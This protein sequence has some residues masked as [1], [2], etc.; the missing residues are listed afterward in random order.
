[1]SH[2][3]KMQNMK[4]QRMSSSSDCS[5]SDDGKQPSS[6]MKYWEEIRPS[7]TDEEVEPLVSRARNQHLEVS[8]S[9]ECQQNENDDTKIENSQPE[10]SPSTVQS[11]SVPHTVNPNEYHALLVED[12]NCENRQNIGNIN[13]LWRPISVPDSSCRSAMYQQWRSEQPRYD[14]DTDLLAEIDYQFSPPSRSSERVN[15]IDFLDWICSGK[16]CEFIPFV[17]IATAILAIIWLC[18]DLIVPY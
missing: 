17:L 9:K 5:D 13:S 15:S 12:T 14:S 8:S 4:Y 11:R 16:F 3:S 10:N 2:S 1:M 18:L 6:L 7:S